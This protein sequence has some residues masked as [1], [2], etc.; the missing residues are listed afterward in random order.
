MLDGKE[1]IS[2]LKAKIETFDI[3]LKNTNDDLMR[4]HYSSI[5]TAYQSVIIHLWENTV[6]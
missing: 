1:L 2:W 5:I 4:Q 6:K 3:L